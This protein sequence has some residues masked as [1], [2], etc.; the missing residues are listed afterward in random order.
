M[1]L[2]EAVRGGDDC[3]IQFLYSTGMG[4]HFVI[5]SRFVR[6]DFVFIS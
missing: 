3:N 6:S 4:L 5:T 1:R 2:S